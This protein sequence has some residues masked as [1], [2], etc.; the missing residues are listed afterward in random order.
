MGSQTSVTI[1]GV[2]AG[3]FLGVGVWV[4]SVGGF[5]AFTASDNIGDTY[6]FIWNAQ[7]SG[8]TFTAALWAT[9]KSAGTVTITIGCTPGGC[10]FSGGNVFADLFT[11]VV[12]V[13]GGTYHAN[14]GGSCVTGTG[15]ESL[16]S[17]IAAGGGTAGW[18]AIT[19]LNNGGGTMTLTAA[20]ATSD[21]I[22]PAPQSQNTCQ[23]VA[24]AERLCS[25]TSSL[26]AN[27]PIFRVNY[28]SSG[29][30][31]T[32]SDHG[33]VILLGGSNPSTTSNSAC[34][35]N[36]GSPAV[37]LINPNATH[38]VNFNLSIT[39]F[40]AFQSPVNGFINNMTVNIA[41]PYTNGIQVGIGI[42][43]ANCPVDVQP[44]TA[45]CQGTLVTS[46]QN[47][48]FGKGR[49]STVSNAPI[50]A[51]QWVAIAV[52][53]QFSGLDLNETNTLCSTGCFD[54][55][56]LQY[57][58]GGIQPILSGV[59]RCASTG[60]PCNTAGID[61]TGIWAYVT[62]TTVGVPP[63]PP[64]TGG[65]ANNWAQLDCLLPALSNGMCLVVT[66][67]CQTSGSL[68][69]IFIL[70]VVSFLLVTVGFAS[71]HVTKFVAAGDVFIFF[72]LG[73]FFIFVGVNLIESLVTIF[74]LFMGAVVFGKTARN[75]F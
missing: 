19:V 40:Y 28:S 7:T 49:D 70:T 31:S 42:Y 17:S 3:D 12:T 8:Q 46:K 65:C 60:T 29:G 56:H 38:T 66:A 52:S 71:A 43:T 21:G 58:N 6:T 32:F 47:F 33:D 11:N 73:W 74:F 51:G 4:S 48:V 61:S 59:S 62:G 39:L 72:F 41:K 10:S 18:E 25:Y 20:S 22:A 13:L 45:Q 54:S 68:F 34:Y 67:S 35:G 57:A 1:T 30:S 24:T 9:A 44:F 26:T 53:A 64:T 50:S 69:W 75:Y 5:S 15:Q 16:Q 14:C 36:C 2:S 55:G 37:T 63:P 23:T 27:F